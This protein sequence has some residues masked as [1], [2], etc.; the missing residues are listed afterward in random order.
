MADRNEYDPDGNQNG[1]PYN[2]PQPPAAPAPSTPQKQWNTTNDWQ[3]VYNPPSPGDQYWNSWIQA[4]P[5]YRG[6]G[7]SGPSHSPREVEDMWFNFLNQNGYSQGQSSRGNGFLAGGAAYR[8]NLDPLVQKFNESTGMNARS[9]GEDK[10]DFGS[11]ARDVITGNEND[12]WISQPG[13]YGSA[14]YHGPSAPTGGGGAATGGQVSSAPAQSGGGNGNGSENLSSQTKINQGISKELYDMLMARA[15]QGTRIDRNDPNIR[16]QVDPYTAQVERQRR[17]YLADAAESL[18]PLANIR[19]EARVS[20]ERAGQASGLFEGQIIGRELQSRRDEITHALDSLRGQ[21]SAE[22]QTELQ[23]E[24]GYLED[25][26]R[27]YGINS[28]ANTAAGQ[29]GLGRDKLNLDYSDLDWR[30]DPRN[31]NN[32]PRD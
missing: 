7:Y 25:A 8:G 2:P 22:Q 20:S 12:W 32:L 1:N 31:P 18:G 13:S 4:N 14:D 5:T 17:N 27:R 29:L 6:Q 19:G 3:D 23:K 24:L 21:L 26:T 15:K 16:Q 28:D 10:I 30:M 9:A 11:G